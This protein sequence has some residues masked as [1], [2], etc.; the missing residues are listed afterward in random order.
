[1]HDQTGTMNDMDD[2]P[3]TMRRMTEESGQISRSSWSK[4]I[5]W[6]WNPWE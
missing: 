2:L 1:M 3:H 4:N 5:L 6:V